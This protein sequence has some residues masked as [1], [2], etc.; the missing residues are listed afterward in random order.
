MIA[1]KKRLPMLVFTM[2]H[3]PNPFSFMRRSNWM[4]DPT[5]PTSGAGG[6]T[7]TYEYDRGGN[8]LCKKRYAYTT[9]T[10]GTVLQT[11]SYGYDTTWK[12]KMVSYNGQAIT[13]DAIGNPLTDGTW[14]YT[15]EN[16]RQLKQMTSADK[17]V[18]FDYNHEGLRVQKTVT[19]AAGQTV[20]TNYTLHGKNIVHMTQGSNNLHFFYD[21]SNKP[22]IVDF[23]GTQY[24]YAHDLQGDI[25]QIV[26]CDGN[27]VVEYTY[28][29]WGKVLNITG[30]EDLKETLGKIQPFRY[31]GYVYDEENGLYYLRSRYYD[32]TWNR[33]VNEDDSRTIYSSD[34][35]LN[36]VSCEYQKQRKINVQRPYCGIISAK[37]IIVLSEKPCT[38]RRPENVQTAHWTGFD[39]GITGNVRVIT[40]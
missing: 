22:A 25:C 14:T 26:D 39:A 1:T 32:P 21:A 16:G 11:I 33:F 18:T 19:D 7:W 31:R 13:Y 9:G 24:A 30:D 40:A 3:D 37:E 28:D 17:A 27:V 29:A 6:T 5:D 2:N 23:N 4:N 38:C 35:S 10:L 20:I 8:I 34:A 15:W 12:D 36:S